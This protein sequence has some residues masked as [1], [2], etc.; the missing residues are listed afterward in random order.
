MNVLESILLEVILFAFLLLLKSQYF[1][2]EQ[3]SSI[4]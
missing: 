2:V 1:S 4:R 3:H